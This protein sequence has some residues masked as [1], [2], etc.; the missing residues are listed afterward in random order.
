MVGSPGLN[1]CTESG[2]CGGFGW[3]PACSAAMPHASCRN[4]SKAPKR[5]LWDTMRES[6]AMVDKGGLSGAFCLTSCAGCAL[7]VMV[8]LDCY[9][10]ALKHKHKHNKAAM[11]LS[12]ARSTKVVLPGLS[13]QVA[14][15]VSACLVLLCC[16]SGSGSHVQAAPVPIIIDTDIGIGNQTSKASAEPSVSLSFPPG[17]SFVV[18]SHG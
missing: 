16:A 17:L 18:Y 7:V 6:D 3:L 11:S 15:V 2:H 8:T 5:R 9:H 4:S 13:A 1:T 14:V 12:T 10:H